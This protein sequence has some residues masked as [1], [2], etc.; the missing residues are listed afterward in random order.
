MDPGDDVSLLEVDGHRGVAVRV[1]VAV[2]VSHDAVL[3]FVRHHETEGPLGIPAQAVA[4]LVGVQQT[5]GVVESSAVKAVVAVELAGIDDRPQ[6]HV[7]FR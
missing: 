5:V 4:Q 7:G 6:P 2:G 1:D 3:D